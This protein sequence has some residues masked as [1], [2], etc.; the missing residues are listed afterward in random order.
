MNLFPLF[1]GINPPV[2]IA[3]KLL[4]FLVQFLV[5]FSGVSSRIVF[6]FLSRRKLGDEVWRPSPSCIGYGLIPNFFLVVP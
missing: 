6:G 5:G 2:W 4:L 3:K 1:F